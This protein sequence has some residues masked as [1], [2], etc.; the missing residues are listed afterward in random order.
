MDWT[1]HSDFCVSVNRPYLTKTLFSGRDVDPLTAVR[2]RNGVPKQKSRS[3]TLAGRSTG[4]YAPSI[5]F[6][7]SFV[8]SMP[9]PE[10]STEIHRVISGPRLYSY[11]R[12]VG[13]GSLEDAL[14]LYRLNAK[15]S[16]TFIF[17]IQ[18]V[19]V[20]FRNAL[21]TQL[22]SHLG[23]A[24]WLIRLI[25]DPA[26]NPTLWSSRQVDKVLN[27]YVRY[28]ESKRCPP[29]Q[30][31]MI[32]DLELGFW[33]EFVDKTWQRHR[34][35]PQLKGAFPNLPASITRGP[36]FSALN[37]LRKFRNRIAHHEVIISPTTTP[38]DTHGVALNAIEWM[39]RDTSEWTRRHSQV[40][41]TWLEILTEKSNRGWTGF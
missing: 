9:P 26:S 41:T 2:S 5:G 35:W 10:L 30:D 22:D 3:L 25:W 7:I 13:N 18:S 8:K 36:V 12:L 6:I 31:D 4:I 29:S 21:A 14:L 16:G 23:T 27:A 1:Y 33:T 40:E 11:L 32:S 34:L 28:V 37:R 17:P 39:S 20:A 24:D 38:I 15:L 19:E